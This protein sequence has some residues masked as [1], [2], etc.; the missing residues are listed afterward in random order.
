MQESQTLNT[1]KWLIF[2]IIN[3]WLVPTDIDRRLICGLVD[4]PFSGDTKK[5][6]NPYLIP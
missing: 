3:K 4:L 6:P 5:Q 1:T 2:S